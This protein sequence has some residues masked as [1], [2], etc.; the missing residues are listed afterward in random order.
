MK[1]KKLPPHVKNA[2][3][4]IID[5]LKSGEILPHQGSRKIF[6]PAI[7]SFDIGKYWRV[8]VRRNGKEFSIIG[9]MSH[10]EYNN[11]LKHR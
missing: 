3:I 6:D 11:W 2:A 5:K 8:V 10:S 1:T 7:V 9:V 4:E